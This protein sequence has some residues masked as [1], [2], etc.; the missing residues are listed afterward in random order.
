[1]IL[2]V[3]EISTI[4]NFSG[5]VPIT[6]SIVALMCPAPNPDIRLTEAFIASVILVLLSTFIL[7][8]C[9]HVLGRHFTYHLT[10]RDQHELIASGPYSVVR[11]PSYFGT[12]LLVAGVPLSHVSNGSWLT[13]CG[14]ANQSSMPLIAAWILWWVWAFTVCVRRARAEDAQLRKQFGKQWDEYAARVSWWFVPGLL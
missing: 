3:L 11:H 14:F 2:A 4:L 1:L 10:I 9:Y 7:L 5:L 6:P 13:E 12:L 8:R